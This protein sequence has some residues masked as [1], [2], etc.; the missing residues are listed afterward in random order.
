MTMITNSSSV[1][2]GE[3][4]RF[5]AGHIGQKKV[6]KG[7]NEV[8]IHGLNW[9]CGDFL[10][11]KERKDKG[12]LGTAAIGPGIL[13]AREVQHE[14]RRRIVRRITVSPRL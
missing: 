6:G 5:F 14:P 12:G 4:V 9:F 10:H 7:T 11:F 2:Q 3:K 1:P 8:G 13:G